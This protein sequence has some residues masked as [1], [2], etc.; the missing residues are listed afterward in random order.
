MCVAGGGLDFGSA[1]EL[2]TS[3]AAFAKSKCRASCSLGSREGPNASHGSYGEDLAAICDWPAL[4]ALPE[5]G[6]FHHESHT[7]Q[8]LERT[9][10]RLRP[11][12]AYG[13]GSGDG[14]QATKDVSVGMK[15]PENYESCS[16]NRFRC[17]DSPV[18]KSI[19]HGAGTSVFSRRDFGV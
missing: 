4:S 3:P 1:S 18:I 14:A 15:G 10:I 12:R 19:K 17:L 11:Q 16:S 2:C 6:F 7:A 5:M 9:L 8:R 13:V